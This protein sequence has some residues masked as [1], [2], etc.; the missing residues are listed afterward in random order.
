MFDHKYTSPSSDAETTCDKSSLRLALIGKFSF[1]WPLILKMIFPFL[2]SKNLTLESFVV[3][4]AT[5]KE[6]KSIPVTLRP[7]EN[8]PRVFRQLITVIRVSFPELWLYPY[9][10]F[11]KDCPFSVP[12]TTMSPLIRPTHNLSP[13]LVILS[14][15]I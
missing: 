3:T 4:I 11:C 9:D 7:D 15:V 14:A 6:R 10:S 2:M 13:L 12:Y 8:L 5:L 1:L